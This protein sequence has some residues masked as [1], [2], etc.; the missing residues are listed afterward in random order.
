MLQPAIRPVA[1]DEQRRLVPDKQRDDRTDQICQ[2][3][4]PAD[5]SILHMMDQ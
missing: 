4:A 2:I 3:N 5:K 1:V